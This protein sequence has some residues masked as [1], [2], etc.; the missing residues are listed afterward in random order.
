MNRNANANQ[1]PSHLSLL[2]RAGKQLSVAIGRAKAAYTHY[3]SR[4]IRRLREESRILVK[5]KVPK[6]EAARLIN[7][8]FSIKNFPETRYLEI[9]VERGFTFEDVNARS[10][11]GV[12]PKFKFNKRLK[13]RRV[14]LFETDSNYYFAHLARSNQFDIVFLDGLH[15][16][17]Q[18]YED[19]R[20]ALGHVHERTVIII[21]DTVPCDEFSAIPNQQESHVLR[22]LANKVGDGSWHGD[23][24]KVV[25]ALNKLTEFPIEYAT[26]KDLANPKTVVWLKKD[27]SWPQTLPTFQDFYAEFSDYFGVDFIHESLNPMNLS[28]FYELI[29]SDL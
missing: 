12:D 16:A 24:F 19:L 7:T 15:T 29:S 9:G 1:N 21:D 17:A 27:A 14:K 10:K 18:T 22:T 8:I 3:V 25:L 11:V 4:R 5:G 13:P 26:I 23:V 6:T 20:N 2:S 28:D